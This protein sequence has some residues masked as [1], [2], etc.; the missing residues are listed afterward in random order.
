MFNISRTLLLI[1]DVQNDFCPAYTNSSGWSHE[2]GALAVKD[3]GAVIAPLNAL[4]KAL[5]LKNGRVAATQDWHPNNHVS[6]ASS[7]K[8]KNPGDTVDTDSVK[9]QTLWPD[10]CVQGTVGAALHDELDLKPVS[11]IIRKGINVDIDSYSAFFENDRCTSTGLE[12]GIKQMNI[13]TVIIG[14]LATDYCVFYSAMDSRRLGFHTIVASDAV[15]GVGI[16][17][18]S[19]EKAESM[20]K[21]AGVDFIAS[22]ELLDNIRRR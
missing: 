4:S 2:D 5:V 22:K 20:M 11:L 1:I 8:N 3:G 21:A 10:H 7:Y 9:G 12:G 19:V 18:G 6:F 15:R 14:G 16:P 17:E 13:E